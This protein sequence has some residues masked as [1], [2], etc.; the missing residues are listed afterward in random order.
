MNRPP[1]SA[2]L[3]PPARVALLAALSLPPQHPGVCRPLQRAY[4]TTAA[5][6]LLLLAAGVTDIGGHP[7]A[8]TT[9]GGV[10]Q[11]QFMNSSDLVKQFSEYVVDIDP[12]YEVG[13]DDVV[14]KWVGEHK[15]N[16]GG[17]EAELD[18]Q[19]IMG[20]S[21]VKYTRDLP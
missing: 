13:T 19:F 3:A 9:S 17:V 6:Y 16:D 11:G 2:A 20:V 1:T 18:I 14:S 10:F 12:S 21:P 7:A 4:R 5:K 15:E 8:E